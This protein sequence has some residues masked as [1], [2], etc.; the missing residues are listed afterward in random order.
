MYVLPVASL[1]NLALS[2][3]PSIVYLLTL[4]PRNLLNECVIISQSLPE[5]EGQLAR[6]WYKLHTLYAQEAKIAQSE[7]FTTK[8]RRLRKKL[9]DGVERPEAEDSE[10]S[11]NQL[12]LWMLW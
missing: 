8:A 5:G 12:N 7:E 10:E 11:Y 4:F 2:A 6:A 1:I 3:R 9:L